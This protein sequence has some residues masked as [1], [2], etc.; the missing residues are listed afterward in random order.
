MTA[1]SHRRCWSCAVDDPGI[2]PQGAG[3]AAAGGGQLGLAGGGAAV[4]ALV[5][6]GAAELSYFEA[7]REWL[8]ERTR[9]INRRLLRL[10]QE[11]SQ[12]GSARRETL[13]PGGP[14]GRRR[15]GRPFEQFETVD[16]CTTDIL[17]TLQ[18]FDRQRDFLRPHRDRLYSALLNWEPILKAWEELPGNLAKEA[19]GVWRVVDDT[20][21]FLAPRYISV[22]EWQSLI[23]TRPRQDRARPV[24]LG[25]G[26]L[27][28]TAPPR[29]TQAQPGTEQA[30]P[31]QEAHQ[32]AVHA[33]ELQVLADPQL[34]L[35]GDRRG[36]PLAM[37]P[38]MKS[39]SWAC[40]LGSKLATTLS[41]ACCSRAR[42]AL[43]LGQES[44][45]VGQRASITAKVRPFGRAASA[46]SARRMRAHTSHSQAC[47]V[48][49]GHHPADRPADLGGALR[50]VLHAVEL[51]RTHTSN[52]S[53]TLLPAGSTRSSSVLRTPR[54]RSATCA[55][56]TQPTSGRPAPA[57]CPR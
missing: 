41:V 49:V 23:A 30:A 32:R 18:N 25:M 19:D 14:I 42:R 57:P 55:P 48:V 10:S 31:D 22:Q 21:R 24:G 56:S 4:A 52:A 35:V 20:Y 3:G 36:V 7:L 11:A 43:V 15:H 8:L 34:E 50:V 33:D 26:E 47:T 37:T 45:Q 9:A 38:A 6:T 12:H 5:E 53:R 13:C 29:R 16:A 2:R 46:S 1:P 28:P 54:T 27:R 51:R 17:D 40:A 39:E 44:A